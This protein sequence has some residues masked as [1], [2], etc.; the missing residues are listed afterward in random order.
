M[1][2]SRHTLQIFT[3][4]F[5]ISCCITALAGKEERV[6]RAHTFSKVKRHS[7][8]KRR[9]R[10]AETARFLGGSYIAG[11]A[12]PAPVSSTFKKRPAPIRTDIPDSTYSSSTHMQSAK[13]PA[14][15]LNS[16]SGGR[17]APAPRAAPLHDT[18]SV[19]S[20]SSDLPSVTP[21]RPRRS[22]SAPSP[23]RRPTE[24]FHTPLSSASGTPASC[25]DM[26]LTTPSTSPSM[27]SIPAESSHFTTPSHSPQH[28]TH[29][30]DTPMVSAEEASSLLP[31]PPSARVPDHRVLSASPIFK[32]PED[33]HDDSLDMSH[34]ASMNGIFLPHA[35][36]I[37]RDLRNLHRIGD[38]KIKLFFCYA[39][40]SDSEERTEKQE[41]LK[42]MR[43]LLLRA[44]ID[45]ELDIVSNPTG[46]IAPFKEKLREVDHVAL[47]CDE[48]FDRR[49]AASGSMEES[50]LSREIEIIKV[51]CHK[52][53]KYLF[54][55]ALEGYGGDSLRHLFPK[56]PIY[57]DMTERAF[58]LP[59]VLK[60]AYQ[61]YS[62]RLS[63]MDREGTMR[64]NLSRIEN[65]I[66]TLENLIKNPAEASNLLKARKFIPP[67]KLSFTV[68]KEI[69]KFECIKYGEFVEAFAPT[70]EETEE[71][72]DQIRIRLIG[73][74]YQELQ[75][76]RAKATTLLE[77]A[78]IHQQIGNL[79]ME[80]KKFYKDH[81]I[82][83][84]AL[85]RTL[86][87]L[88]KLQL[89][90]SNDLFSEINTTWAEQEMSASFLKVAQLHAS[91]GLLR[92]ANKSPLYY[93]DQAAPLDSINP[94]IHLMRICYLEN[95]L[96]SYE[97][98]FV[99]LNKVKDRSLIQNA[100]A[101][102]LEPEKKEIKRKLPLLKPLISERNQTLLETVE[103]LTRSHGIRQSR[104]RAHLTSMSGVEEDI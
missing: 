8:D 46:S 62:H 14:V 21:T 2:C 99:A 58:M 38:P 1:L 19:T 17:A 73:L 15:G 20:L 35:Y 7:P 48:S 18:S 97:L 72:M 6:R 28:R 40:P 86:G 44:G 29:V 24:S 69:E 43:E 34:I 39:W 74:P 49:V 37:L 95:D 53:S 12:R 82:K 70:R 32:L 103:T 94:K 68:E 5:T 101:T 64:H 90:Y 30:L 71:T 27:H 33:V 80:Q 54:P 51:E 83:F 93:I 3:F 84:E 89:L 23:Q 52:N 41:R 76:R 56:D 50:H 16:V 57:R 42:E 87:R 85:R 61:S 67:Y 47:F 66:S 92:N 79:L 10:E 65:K 13:P 75:K 98:A 36:N 31:L 77:R 25:T 102:M 104:F 60:I 4:F 91:T 100:Y 11:S 59:E 81:Q 26:P 22:R 55:I 96:E 78:L 45:V 88:A 63:R 9:R